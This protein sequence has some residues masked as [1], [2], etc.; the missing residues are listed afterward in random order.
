MDAVKCN[1]CGRYYDKRTFV[2]TT[3]KGNGR[4][5]YSCL[6][7]DSKE[8]DLCPE[9]EESFNEWFNKTPTK[10]KFLVDKNYSCEYD[11]GND[12]CWFHGKPI[13]LIDDCL[14]AKE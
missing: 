12:F 13:E 5:F 3:R 9:C 11:N 4:D 7:S 1:R 10:C 2:I 6:R 8:F 14:E